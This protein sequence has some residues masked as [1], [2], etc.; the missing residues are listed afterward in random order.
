MQAV[1]TMV[2]LGNPAHIPFVTALEDIVT[3]LVPGW[4]NKQTLPSVKKKFS[5]GKDLQLLATALAS[6]VKLSQSNIH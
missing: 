5:Y 3:I 6:Y 2:S 1:W 4:R